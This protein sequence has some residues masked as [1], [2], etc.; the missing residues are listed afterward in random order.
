ML[1]L[2]HTGITLGFVNLACRI[3]LK[4]TSCRGK[5]SKDKG[6]SFKKIKKLASARSGPPA[7]SDPLINSYSPANSTNLK[8]DY[9]LVLLGSMF[10]DI[11]DK[12]LGMLIFPD[13]IA[14]GR[15]YTHTLLVNLILV[16]A[17]IYLFKRKKP[18]FLFF[19]L[20]SM[21]HLILDRMWL[22]PQTLFWPLYG[23]GFSKEDISSWWENIF[24][25]LFKDP[26]VYLPEIMGATI[27]AAFGI[28]LI[29]RKAL[30]KFLLE[31]TLP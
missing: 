14:N 30:G 22:T 24:Q 12:P 16:V 11:V 21:F 26:S 1:L 13:L 23:W 17:G 9:R 18:C 6:A 5:K 31:G 2:A 8:V 20:S 15:I 3:L 25:A 10:P 28:I 19:S 29:K 4:I 27:L 7:N